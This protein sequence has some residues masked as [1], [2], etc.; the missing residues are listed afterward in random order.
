M[1][2]RNSHTPAAATR[3]RAAST[4][5][6]S[7]TVL[8]VLFHYVSARRPSRASYPQPPLARFATK[9]REK[10]WLGEVFESFNDHLAPALQANRPVV[11][12]VEVQAYCL[13]SGRWHAG[14]ENM[15]GHGIGSVAPNGLEFHAPRLPIEGIGERAV[16]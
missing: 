1:L 14:R 16:R 12:N 13:P 7:I 10:C 6:R 5:S 3:E 11:E 15:S 9:R 8:D 4:S 2:A